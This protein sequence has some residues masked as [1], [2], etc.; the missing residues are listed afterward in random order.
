MRNITLNDADKNQLEILLATCKNKVIRK[1]SQILLLSNKGHSLASIAK[2]LDIHWNTASRLLDKWEITN[3]DDRLSAL[4][5][6]EGKGAKMKLKP[7][8]E[9]LPELLEQ[10][11]RNLKPILDILEKEYSVKVCK[12]TLQNFLKGSGL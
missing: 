12:L 9:I 11:S 10:Y 5:S 7:V 3:E 8:T 2:L 1:R 4:Y 6:R